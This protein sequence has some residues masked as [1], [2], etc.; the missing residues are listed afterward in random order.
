MLVSTIMP[1]IRSNGSPWFVAN[2]NRTL[3]LFEYY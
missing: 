1:D 2:L 3:W